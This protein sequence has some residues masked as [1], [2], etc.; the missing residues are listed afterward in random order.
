MK[1]LLTALK[2]RWPTREQIL[3]HRHLRRVRP[4]LDHGWLWHPT[5]H[6]VPGAVAAGMVAAMLPA[7]LQTLSAVF[8]AFRFRL[9]LPTAL[10]GT[11]ISN[12]F[13]ILPIY[14]LAYEFG[15]L[16][17]GRPF[18]RF[19]DLQRAAANDVWSLWPLLGWPWLLG[20]V[21]LTA[22]CATLGY[23]LS[24][25]LWVCATHWRWRQRLQARARHQPRKR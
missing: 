18:L 10:L 5:R 8:F 6:S 12:P 21:L 25:G 15:A 17:L 11:L 1:R 22:G 4:W 23:C 7:P 3:A 24:R 20:L 2:A 19:S 9:H 16:L 14:W 13:T